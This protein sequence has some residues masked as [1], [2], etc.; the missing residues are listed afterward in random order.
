[1]RIA[2][3]VSR[4]QRCL[5]RIGKPVAIGQGAFIE[6]GITTIANIA[7]ALQQSALDIFNLQLSQI[8][9]PQLPDGDQ[10][11]Q[12]MAEENTIQS[13]LHALYQRRIAERSCNGR[14]N[15]G[16]D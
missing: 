13:S 3:K 7:N 8:A 16:P 6:C 2:L 10:H 1:M 9:R 11:I 4:D 5:R 12:L 15:H 14:D